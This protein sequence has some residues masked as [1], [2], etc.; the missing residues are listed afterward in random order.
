MIRRVRLLGGRLKKQAE[1]MG[2]VD[3]D[4][5][6]IEIVDYTPL[7]V[8]KLTKVVGSPTT[9]LQKHFLGMKDCSKCDGGGLNN[10]YDGKTLKA[11]DICTN[12]GGRGLVKP[13][14]TNCKFC[15][16]TNIRDTGACHICLDC[17][18]KWAFVDECN[19]DTGDD[20]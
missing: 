11:E 20:D 10:S 12:C 17:N 7:A 16:S 1:D 13:D 3:N 4:V 5:V 18:K 15:N 14:I 9:F 8:F 2:L 6:L 19:C